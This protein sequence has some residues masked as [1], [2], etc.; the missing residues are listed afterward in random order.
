MVEPKCM[1]GN[2]GYRASE[3]CAANHSVIASICALLY[4]L[5]IWGMTVPARASSR[6]ASSF[7]V[8]AARVCPCNRGMAFVTG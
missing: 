6:N 4:P 3:G 5:T 2:V 7:A 8:S 1:E